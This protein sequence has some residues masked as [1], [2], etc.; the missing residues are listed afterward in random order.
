MFEAAELFS[1]TEGFVVAPESAHAVKAAIDQG[2][3]A[4]TD[5]EEA[6]ADSDCFIICVPTPI[7]ENNRPNLN[8]NSMTQF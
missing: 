2:V 5:S 6:L 8:K 1:R 4:T 3:S 7:Q